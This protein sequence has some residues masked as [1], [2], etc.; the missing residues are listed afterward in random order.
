MD[1]L[2]DDA[3]AAAWSTSTT[4]LGLQADCGGAAAAEVNR[5]STSRS[6]ESYLF[7]FLRSIADRWICHADRRLS[8]SQD[9]L[10]CLGRPWHILLV[11]AARPVSPESL[12]R[13]PHGSI[14]KYSILLGSHEPGSYSW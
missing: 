14:G 10:R 6:F 3:A 9:V 12:D 11:L 13:K 4:I 2:G 5:S 7:L 8:S 1:P